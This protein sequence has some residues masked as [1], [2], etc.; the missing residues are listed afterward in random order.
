MSKK[1]VLDINANMNFKDLLFHIRLNGYGYIG[2]QYSGSGDSGSIDDVFLVPKDCAT[3]DEEGQ[4]ICNYSSYELEKKC[5]HTLP[6][7]IIDILER[8]IYSHIL[9]DA[10]DWYNNDGGGGIGYICTENGD[11]SSNHYIY[12]TETEDEVIIGN[13]FI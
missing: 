9:D 11:F 4:I 12:I 13:L 10:T 3:Q 8:K 7:D 2:F 6:K 1:Q 5:E